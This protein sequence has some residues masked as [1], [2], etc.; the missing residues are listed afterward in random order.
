M[1]QMMLSD[2]LPIFLGWIHEIA[3]C[4][5][6]GGQE[7]PEI[8]KARRGRPSFSTERGDSDD[9]IAS[10]NGILQGCVGV[11]SNASFPSDLRARCYLECQFKEEDG[12]A[13]RVPALLEAPI[14]RL[15]FLLDEAK[16]VLSAP[17]YWAARSHSGPQASRDLDILNQ[18]A[19]SIEE[20]EMHKSWDNSS[21]ETIKLWQLYGESP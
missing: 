21:L 11:D 8:C 3:Y 1:E 19:N 14:V 16:R 7:I 6:Q 4:T 17:F 18:A 9:A 5:E 15:S 20:P 13:A 10:E 2:F 12:G